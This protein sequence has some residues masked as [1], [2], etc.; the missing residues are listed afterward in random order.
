MTSFCP[1]ER[2]RLGE[3]FQDTEFS[4]IPGNKILLKHCMILLRPFI[5]FDDHFDPV[6]DTHIIKVVRSNGLSCRPLKL[7]YCEILILKY[8]DLF[9]DAV[10]TLEEFLPESKPL[11]LKREN[12]ISRNKT[13]IKVNAIRKGLV[14]PGSLQVA[15]QQSP[16]M[17][18][19]Y[20]S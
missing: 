10:K 17:R 1:E 6:F 5:W 19:F 13:G 7:D 20:P 2:S 12:I 3:L 15:M 8:E 9:S 11:T 4:S 14:L 16:Y 18:A